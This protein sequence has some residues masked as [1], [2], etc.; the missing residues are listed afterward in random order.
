MDCCYFVVTTYIDED[1]R[2]E[3]EEYIREVKPIVESYGGEYLVRTEQVTALTEKWKPDRVIIIRF[4][5]LKCLKECFSSE[6]YMEIKDKRER[7]VISQAVI[8]PGIGTA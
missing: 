6:Q 3:Y 1:N 4:P 8:V 7:S 2:D 5:S